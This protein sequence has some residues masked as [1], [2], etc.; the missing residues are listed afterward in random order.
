MV[1]EGN[2]IK[3]DMQV[4]ELFVKNIVYILLY[5]NYTRITLF[6]LHIQGQKPHI[7]HLQ[8]MSCW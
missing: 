1:F 5:F 4:G 6:Y 7:A 3:L 2:D 8:Q